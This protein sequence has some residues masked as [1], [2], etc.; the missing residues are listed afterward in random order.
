[1]KVS[2]GVLTPSFS[3]GNEFYTAQVDFSMTSVRVLP[4]VH[5]RHAVCYVSTPGS[6]N[7][8]L[9]CASNA[10]SHAIRLPK[11][12]RR[13]IEVTVSVPGEKGCR[14]YR[15]VVQREQIPNVSKE[16]TQRDA[17]LK[18]QGYLNRLNMV[19][20]AGFCIFSATLAIEQWR[21]VCVRA[22]HDAAMAL[23]ARKHY[24]RSQAKKIRDWRHL[25]AIDA[26]KQDAVWRGFTAWRRTWFK[27]VTTIWRVTSGQSLHAKTHP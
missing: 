21:T 16:E 14:G 27:R 18:Q 7:P 20:K 12:G 3:S 22:Q 2:S 1:M 11:N 15:V 26:R 13:T 24:V 10:W 8:T 4:I 17:T 5:Y 23:R 19:G 9:L 6:T 25:D